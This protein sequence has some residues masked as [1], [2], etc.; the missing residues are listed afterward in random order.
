MPAARGLHGGQRLGQ[1]HRGGLRLAPALHS[2]VPAF[3]PRSEIT[4]RKRHADQFPVGEHRAR[5]L[6]AV[7][8]Q[9]VDARRR[10][11][12]CSARRRPSPRRCGRS[13]SG[14]RPPERR[15][16]HRP[17]DA[18]LVVVLLDGRAQQRVTP[19]P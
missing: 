11:S 1:R 4:T 13:R 6:A 2:T 10:S 8:E 9:H 5:A 12:S 19:M 3:R 17:D 16:R 7:V 15:H 18:A 14:R